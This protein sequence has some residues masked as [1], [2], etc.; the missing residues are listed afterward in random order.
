MAAK[1]KRGLTAFLIDVTDPSMT[2]TRLKQMDTAKTAA[3]YGIPV[4]TVE[5]Y[6]RWQLGQGGGA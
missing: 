2:T 4:S 3:H 5:T 6:R 1:P